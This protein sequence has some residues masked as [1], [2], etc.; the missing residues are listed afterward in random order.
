MFGFLN[1]IKNK[2]LAKD[3]LLLAID[4]IVAV[5]VFVI[6]AIIQIV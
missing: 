1:K 2:D 3:S 5:T 4:A 6:Y